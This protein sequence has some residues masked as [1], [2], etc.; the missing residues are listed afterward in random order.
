ME[1]ANVKVQI[2]KIFV[3]FI[4]YKTEKSKIY[5]TF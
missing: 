2:S 1:K 5:L 3:F 4:A